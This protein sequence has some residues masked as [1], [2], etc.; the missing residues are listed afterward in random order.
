MRD[1]ALTHQG[2]Q[3]LLESG[4]GAVWLNDGRPIRADE[5]NGKLVVYHKL[6][7]WRLATITGEVVASL[8]HDP[9]N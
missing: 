6:L 1:A 7:R 9:A 3:T 4:V 2:I 8:T 5:A